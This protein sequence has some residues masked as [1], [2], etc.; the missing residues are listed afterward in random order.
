LPRIRTNIVGSDDLASGGLPQG[1]S[2][3]VSGSA[4]SGQTLFGAEFNS[5]MSVTRAAI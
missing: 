4:G 2:V 3:V 5:P 1:R